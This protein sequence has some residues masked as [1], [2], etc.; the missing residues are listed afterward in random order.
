MRALCLATA[1]VLL[2][3]ATAWAQKPLPP[4][5]MPKNGTLATIVR[6]AELYSNADDNSDR[7][8][9]VLPGRELVVVERNGK[10][11]RVF[12]N[13]DTPDT[14][15]ADRPEFGSETE[16][17]PISGW[18]IDKG[19]VD[20]NTPRGDQILFGAADQTEQKRRDCFIGA[21]S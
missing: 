19:I 15:E 1:S 12:A 13:T 21:W 16:A 2:A 17:Q 10:W 7:M 3:A 4:V 11:L 9:N 20:I 5:K 18:I 6:D 14:R 8:A